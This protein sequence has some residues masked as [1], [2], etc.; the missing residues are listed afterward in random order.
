MH[1]NGFFTWDYHGVI[2][3]I[4]LH[5]HKEFIKLQKDWLEMY[6]LG[7]YPIVFESIRMYQ[8]SYLTDCI[9]GYFIMK[10]L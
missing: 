8:R 10:E 4:T 1:V 3:P 9:L 5:D 7:T 6:K 2:M